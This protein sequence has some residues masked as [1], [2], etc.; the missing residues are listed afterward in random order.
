MSAFQASPRGGDMEVELL[1]EQK[2]V[3]L[4]GDAVIVLKGS[5][6]VN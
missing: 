3:L 4:K 6:E 2:R 5:L 1:E